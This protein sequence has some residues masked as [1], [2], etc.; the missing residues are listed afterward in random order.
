MR[1]L[2]FLFLIIF[3]FTSHAKDPCAVYKNYMPQ[4]KWYSQLCNSNG[5][6]KARIGGAY[7]T[8]GDA[9]NL[10]PAAIPTLNLPLG[11]EYIVSRKASAYRSSFAFIKGFG[12]AGAA[13]TSNSDDNF[14]GNSIFQAPGA[15]GF[16]PNRFTNASSQ[17]SSQSNGSNSLNEGN[18]QFPTVNLASAVALDRLFSE[19]LGINKTFFESNLGVVAKYNKAAKSFS[20]GIGASLSLWMFSFGYSRSEDP[21]TETSPKVS[22]ETFSAG[23]KTKYFQ[24]EGVM[25]ASHGI[26]SW[27]VGGYTT[28]T[29]SPYYVLDSRKHRPGTFLTLSSNIFGVLATAA[30][31]SYQDVNLQNRFQ[32]HFAAQYQLSS[33]IALEYLNNYVID[34]QSIGVQVLF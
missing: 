26:E 19:G 3:P 16:S 33:K 13:V 14:Y 8:L 20:P 6:S 23:I 22:Y 9:V 17:A 11:V 31:R 30:V 29:G 21:K 7:S 1:L 18:V 15:K 28:F 2:I 12:S 34:H 5:T 10:N 25:I 24:L 27:V 4:P 32:Y